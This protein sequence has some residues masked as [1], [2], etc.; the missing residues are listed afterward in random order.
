MFGASLIVCGVLLLFKPV[1]RNILAS[2]II[3]LTIGMHFQSTTLYQREWNK[4]SQFFWQLTWR[5]PSLKSGTIVIS[6]AIPLF[7]YGDNNLTPVLNW[8]YSPKQTS[9][10][11]SY[12]FFDMGERLG[13]NLPVLEPGLPVDHGYRFVTF[14]S[15]SSNLLPVF[16]KEESCLKVIDQQNARTLSIPK[17][18]RGAAQFSKPEERIVTEGEAVPPV[19]IPE[20]AHEWCYYYQKAELAAQ[21]GNWAGVMDLYSEV[22]RTGYEPSDKTE[23]VP[24]IEALAVTGNID[25][26]IKI[27]KRSLEQ[28]DAKPAVCG[29]W[30]NVL[31]TNP[32]NR[33]FVDAIRIVGC[34]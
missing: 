21:S 16:Y 20:P 23:W 32:T 28:E 19:F 24:Y 8:T 29:V 9:T 33:Q 4:L 3:A 27:S 2:M 13:T 7:Y 15:N 11:L 25:T 14:K 12:N 1:F 10:E 31:S 17:R 26:A 34:E 18:L 6:D 5:A 22:L 30:S